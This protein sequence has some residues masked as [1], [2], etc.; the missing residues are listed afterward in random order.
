VA[1]KRKQKKIIPL[2]HFDILKNQIQELVFCLVKTPID[3]HSRL[4]MTSCT[5]QSSLNTYL[6]GGLVSK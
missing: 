2:V 6:T 1:H 4:H 5:I 3:S